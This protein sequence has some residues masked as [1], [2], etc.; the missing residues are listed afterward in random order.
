MDFKSHETFI[1]EAWH[2]KV[3]QF[4]SLSRFGGH[5]RAA[6]QQ[7]F[8]EIIHFVIK[9]PNFLWKLSKVY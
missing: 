5:S 2:T 7:I 9:A 1:P 3:R 6:K 4:H 8:D